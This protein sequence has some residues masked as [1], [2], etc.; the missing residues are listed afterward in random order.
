MIHFVD[1][2]HW[3]HLRFE[4]IDYDYLLKLWLVLT[5]FPHPV[6]ECME[7]LFLRWSILELFGLSD[8]W[9][10]NYFRLGYF[11]ACQRL[12][13]CNLLM[14]QGS[15]GYLKLKNSKK[16]KKEL[17][18]ELRKYSQCKLMPY[19]SASSNSFLNVFKIFW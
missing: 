19:P 13:I 16:L 11:W 15:T 12:H 17:E 5:Y 14:G 1:L 9:H 2:N 3:W 7:S 4:W 18:L 6:W 10:K 8:R